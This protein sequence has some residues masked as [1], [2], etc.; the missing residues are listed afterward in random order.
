[1]EASW[2]PLIEVLKK[3]N[4][5]RK[6]EKDQNPIKSYEV[7][8][9]NQSHKSITHLNH[10]KQVTCGMMSHTRFKKLWLPGI[11]GNMDTANG[12]LNMKITKILQNFMNDA[13]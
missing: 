5:G 4:K 1:M 12:K 3:R 13:F 9:T 2:K 8:H 6:V 11:H 10:T 7:N